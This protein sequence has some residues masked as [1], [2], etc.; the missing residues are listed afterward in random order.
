VE[1]IKDLLEAGAD[2]EALDH[3]YKT[4]CA[5]AVLEGQANAVSFFLRRGITPDTVIL[6]E[7]TSPAWA[8]QYGLL[9]VMDVL[10][11]AGADMEAVTQD[12]ETVL[13]W[14]AMWGQPTSVALLL[15]RGAAPD[16]LDRYGE[17]PL[18]AACARR[19]PVETVTL[20]LLHVEVNQRRRS[21]RRTALAVAAT[22]G[23]VEAIKPL[24]ESGAGPTIED[25]CGST[26]L[27]L[28]AQYGQADFALALLEVNAA[29]CEFIDE[30]DSRGRT[31]LF[32]AT[33]YGHEQV[34]RVLLAKGSLARNYLTR[35]G[36]SPLEFAND[37]QVGKFNLRAVWEWLACPYY[38][39]VDRCAALKASAKTRRASQPVIC[40]RCT[41]A[42]STYD[43][44][45]HCA[46]C[47]NGDLDICIEC[48][49]GLTCF[50][51]SHLLQKRIFVDG[52][53][54]MPV[55]HDYY[56]F[57]NLHLGLGKCS[58]A[59]TG[60]KSRITTT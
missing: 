58:K 13:F 59:Q 37:H 53:N 32:L 19:G 6:E 26:P 55:P 43:T 5:N 40:C 15:A 47:L 50:K 54:W 3:G 29:A 49:S 17:T 30:P 22:V 24:L 2:I 39:D 20:L 44:H 31:P 27:A 1:I 33:L 51:S 48:A 8:A 12:G 45:F 57:I 34:V 35:A 4:A 16:A 56:Y 11:D 46:I 14:A 41:L 23:F 21:D 7:G 60:T 42:L 28:A 38:A 18:H 10:L 36:R 25:A 52:R 9:Q